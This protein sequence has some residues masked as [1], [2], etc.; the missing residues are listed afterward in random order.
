MICFVS[1]IEIVIIVLFDLLDFAMQDMLLWN[2]LEVREMSEDHRWL[3]TL[4]LEEMIDVSLFSETDD[5]DSD[6]SDY[7]DNLLS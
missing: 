6:L 5:D 3:F 1:L 7:A 4:D 2:Y